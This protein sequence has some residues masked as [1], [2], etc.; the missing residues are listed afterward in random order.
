MKNLVSKA[1]VDP[2]TDNAT[3]FPAWLRPMLRDEFRKMAV[4]DVVKFDAEGQRDVWLLA[5]SYCHRV[6]YS[7]GATFRTRTVDGVGFVK[8]IA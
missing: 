5:Q 7:I 6:G 1:D 4:G 8:R 3:T 2:F